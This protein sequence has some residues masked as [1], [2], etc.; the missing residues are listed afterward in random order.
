MPPIPM[1]NMSVSYW[2]QNL[3]A[4]VFCWYIIG[5]K[6]KEQPH[7][8]KF[9]LHVLFLSACFFAVHAILSVLAFQ[10]HIF[11]GI[12]SWLS[13]VVGATLYGAFFSR[14]SQNVKL[15][16]IAA[17]ISVVITLFELGAVLG[18]Y[19]MMRI[20]GFI[21]FVMQVLSCICLLASGI[22]MGKYRIAKYDVSVHAARL[23]MLCCVVTSLCV[24]VF[25]IFAVHVFPR[26]G[27]EGILSLVSIMLF[28]LFVIIFTC[29][30]LSYHLSREYTQV[31]D[32]TA[33]N[34]MNKSATALMAVT[35]TNFSEFRKIQHDLKNQYSYIRVLMD[36]GDYDGLREYVDE[37]TSTFS[38]PLVSAL[39]CGNHILNLIFNMELTKARNYGITMD[40]KAAPPHDL[41][42]SQLDLVKL[43]SN[44]LDNAIEACIAENTPNPVIEVT[45]GVAGEY[46][47]TQ[48]RN[49][50]Q[51]KASFLRDGMPTTKN[52][53]R[54]HGK[55]ISIV[56]SIIR[57]YSGSIQYSIHD[58]TFFVDFML[59]LKEVSQDGETENSSVR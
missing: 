38:T 41:P 10:F 1:I 16:N 6:K 30:F 45:T 39:D 23:N 5:Y 28:G 24:I 56:R 57:K 7:P 47:F 18:R 36:C 35:E 40:I 19:L 12:G 2:L 52:N 8:M 15:F 54:N 32:L 20:P 50:T 27:D 3:C 49:P 11:A 25:D 42:F 33:E 53:T 9:L 37:M 13:Y 34:Q 21:G 59:C 48:I 14:D 26:G 31:L 4:A 55:G 43:Y 46:L 17:C 22:I 44:V 29:Y 58:G 51:K